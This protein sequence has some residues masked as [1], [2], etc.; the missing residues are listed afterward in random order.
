MLASPDSVDFPLVSVIRA[1]ITARMTWFFATKASLAYGWPDRGLAPAPRP[2]APF[3]WESHQYRHKLWHPLSPG[4]LTPRLPPAAPR[5]TT[6]SEES[7][8]GA[9]RRARTLGPVRR[10]K[11][12]AR[13]SRIPLTG[14]IPVERPGAVAPK[15]N[16]RRASMQPE[17]PF[18][19]CSYPP[20]TVM[21]RHGPLPLAPPAPPRRAP[22]AS[23]EEGTSRQSL[24]PTCCQRVPTGS[25]HS[26]TLGSRRPDRRFYRCSARPHAHTVVS[27]AAFTTAPDSRKRH[28]RPRVVA[29]LLLRSPAVTMIRR[30]PSGPPAPVEP[31]VTYAR[32]VRTRASREVWSLTLPVTPPLRTDPRADPIR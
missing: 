2:S 27:S 8:V 15:T 6:P 29:H 24:Q 25:F 22:P 31:G 26:R 18:T 4:W 7:P 12:P 17:H 14:L 9:T 16:V 21:G 5:T 20:V 28:L 30:C 10:L 13:R 3:S 32:P 1:P 19:S 11:L 23:P